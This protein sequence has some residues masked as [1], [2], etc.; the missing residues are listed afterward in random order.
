MNRNR[1]ILVMAL[2]AGI[3]SCTVL[4][5]GEIHDAVRTG[6]VWKVKQLLAEN[7]DQTDSPVNSVTHEGRTALHIAVY[8]GQLNMVELLLAHK[9][10][11]RAK[12]NYGRTPLHEAIVSGSKEVVGVLLVH[13][14]NINAKDKE[15]GTPLHWAVGRGNTALVRLLLAYKP[16]LN[17]QDNK[18]RTALDIAPRLDVADL[19]RLQGAKSG[20]EVT[21]MAAEAARAKHQPGGKQV[22]H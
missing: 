11:I 14:A 16:D 17:A 15:G 21:R 9:A 6:D 5:A 7:P 4:L 12:D 1:N 20:E 22:L 8:R 3:V 19:L 10:D 2:A 13:K 18:G